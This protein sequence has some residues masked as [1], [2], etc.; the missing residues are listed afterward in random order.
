MGPALLA[1]VALSLINGLVILVCHIAQNSFPKPLSEE[2]EAY[3]LARWRAGDEAARQILIE[4]NLRLVAHIIKKFD[5]TEEDFDDLISVGTIGLI[6]AVDTYDPEK[7]SRLATYASRC[8]ENEV[9]MYL[10]ARKKTRAELSLYDP[11]GTDREG[12]EISYIDVLGTDPEAVSE[13]VAGQMEHDRLWQQLAK[14]TPQERKVLVMR[15]G[16][17]DGARR[18]QREIAR[19]LGI[20]RSYVSRIEKRALSRLSEKF[21]FIENPARPLT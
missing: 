18:T 20:S 1:L 13:M 19:H 11:I 10:R 2:E 8:I 4:R 5:H 9:L 17:K 21:A 12:N 16:L 15:F 7:A 3:Y 14:L 6:K